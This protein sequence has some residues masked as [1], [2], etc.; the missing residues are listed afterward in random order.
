MLFSLPLSLSPSDRGSAR[1]AQKIIARVLLFWERAVVIRLTVAN[2][3]AHRVRNRKTF[4]MYSLA[5]AFIVF[6]TVAANQE[7]Q[8]AQFVQMQ[9]SGAPITCV[10]VTVC[11]CLRL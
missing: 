4:V 1:T 9:Q 8:V 11:A 10:C 2:L 7:I 3:V 5:L 6:L